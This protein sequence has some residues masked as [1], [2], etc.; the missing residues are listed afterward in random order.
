MKNPPKMW[1]RNETAKLG[2]N[3]NKDHAQKKKIEKKNWK[4][5]S[6]LLDFFPIFI[7][8]T[9]S[10]Q[11]K[12]TPCLSYRCHLP[13]TKLFLS[14][15]DSGSE[16]ISK[17]AGYC[18]THRFCKSSCNSEMC[19]YDKKRIGEKKK[20]IK[21]PGLEKNRASVQKKMQNSVLCRVWLE[22]PCFLIPWRLCLSLFPTNLAR[23]KK[24]LISF[25]F[26]KASFS[27]E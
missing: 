3:K 18:P 20:T 14:G 13:K 8:Q 1:E 17:P 21:S 15:C 5:E 9:P 24:P 22:N 25:C 6:T 12:K 2:L 27:K 4:N 19:C 23:I 7:S 10:F 16:K 11:E 26:V